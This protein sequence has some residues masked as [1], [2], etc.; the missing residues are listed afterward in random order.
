[1]NLELLQRIE[2]SSAHR[3]SREDNAQ[4]ILNNHEQFSELI[5]FAFNTSNKNHYKS[6]WILELIL[7][8]RLHLIVPFLDTFSNEIS[9]YTNESALRSISKICMFLAKHMVLTKDQEQKIIESCFD[10]L[11][12]E[13][14]KVATKAYSIRALFELGKKNEWIYL[15]LKRII[16]EDYTKYSAAY[17]AVAREILKKLE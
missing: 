11:I 7:E 10:W 16:S 17:K 4:Y 12:L 14:V 6:C 8:E 15:E 1:M 13:N 2:K 3:K 5:K 9:K